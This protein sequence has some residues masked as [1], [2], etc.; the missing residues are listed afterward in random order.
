MSFRTLKLTVRFNFFYE[1]GDNCS[2][3]KLK[4]SDQVRPAAKKEGVG[5]CKP[6]L[7]QNII[8]DVDNVLAQLQP[9]SVAS[10][11]TI[12]DKHTTLQLDLRDGSEIFEQ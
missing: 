7:A 3:K 11:L 4:N 9:Q 2:C 6:Q 8:D 12:K 10:A 1:Q 5:C